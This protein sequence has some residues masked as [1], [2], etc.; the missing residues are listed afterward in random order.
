M[1]VSFLFLRVYEMCKVAVSD[2][3]I[4][5]DILS[6]DNYRLRTGVCANEIPIVYQ[7]DT[8]V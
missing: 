8:N 3:I 6:D 1:A 7:I 4:D 5:Q 2:L